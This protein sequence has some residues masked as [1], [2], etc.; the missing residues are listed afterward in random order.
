MQ[1]E[2]ESEVRQS[3]T[4]DSWVI[5]LLG[6]QG[7]QYSEMA[8]TLRERDETFQSWMATLDEVAVLLTGRS[9][10]QYVYEGSTECDDLELSSLALF[11]VE[12]SLHRTIEARGVSPTAVVGS[13]LGEFIAFAVA[14]CANPETVMS[15]IHQFTQ[16][17][18]R[19]LPSGGMVAVLGQADHVARMVEATPS[20][21]LISV[22][23][24]SHS[25]VSGL[26]AELDSLI[27]SLESAGLVCFR[28]PV[29]FPFHS[30]FV[31]VVR[32]QLVDVANRLHHRSREGLPRYSSATTGRVRHFDGTHAWNAVGQPIRFVPTITA[33]PNHNRHVYV[34]LTP[35]ASLATI[36]KST[37]TDYETHSIITP[38]HTEEAAIDSLVARLDALGLLNPADPREALS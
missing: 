16:A 37:G 21:T 18:A 2:M 6:G 19:D 33:I 5:F 28:L 31:E 3:L 24:S 11:M 4:Q 12:Y 10:E 38:F 34:D 13:S 15:G 8:R 26:T 27:D 17:A 7:S 1:I 20:T 23:S 25:V 30:S 35:S 14:G 9:I 36:L 29:H 22:H 32:P